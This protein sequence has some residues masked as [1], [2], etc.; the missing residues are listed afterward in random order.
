MSRPS[1]SSSKLIEVSTIFC[2][3]LVYSCM[4]LEAGPARRFIRQRIAVGLSATAW[5]AAL[6]C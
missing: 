6:P 5:L 3:L 2:L 1:A 4:H